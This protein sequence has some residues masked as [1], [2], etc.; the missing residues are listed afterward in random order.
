MQQKVERGL[1]SGKIPL[2]YNKEASGQIVLDA[3]VAENVRYAFIL[4]DLYE[5]SVRKALEKV[6]GCGLRSRNGKPLG[7]STLYAILT[8]PFYAGWVRYNQ[9]LYRGIH[10]PLVTDEV[11]Q[12]VQEHLTSK[13]L[14]LGN[15]QPM[16]K[17]N[18]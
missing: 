13:L 4:V 6:T 18:P 11:F 9:I 10:Q 15:A 3:E 16:L 8:N 12:H 5:Y 17:T 7:V 14:N 1:P 2:G